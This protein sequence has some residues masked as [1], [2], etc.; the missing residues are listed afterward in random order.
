MTAARTPG[1]R[2]ARPRRAK[3]WRPAQR[4]G[5]SQMP[6][7][8]GESTGSYTRRLADLN[9]GIP[10][11]EFWLMFGTPLR[12]DGVPSDPRYSDG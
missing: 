12:Q 11:E 1:T 2:A 9:G 8:G 4:L 3:A 7:I 6:F 10:D 5:R